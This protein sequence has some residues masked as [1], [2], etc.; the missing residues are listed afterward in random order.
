VAITFAAIV[1]RR[2]VEWAE[3]RSVKFMVGPPVS[4][5]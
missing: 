2:A 3:V 5:V 1:G 4:P